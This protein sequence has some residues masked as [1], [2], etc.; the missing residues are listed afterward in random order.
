M[1]LTFL[2]ITYS[3]NYIRIPPTLLPIAHSGSSS[4]CSRPSNISVVFWGPI[5]QSS[6]CSR[7]PPSSCS[8]PPSP[9]GLRGALC[10]SRSF[11]HHR[12]RRAAGNRRTAARWID[13]SIGRC[14]LVLP[15][16]SPRCSLLPLRVATLAIFDLSPCFFT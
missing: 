10:S 13:R 2:I 12:P 1:S 11:R 8:A 5:G 7:L 15:Y 14:F 6:L 16:Y 4:P 3:K 9:F